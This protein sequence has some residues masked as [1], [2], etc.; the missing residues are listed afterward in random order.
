MNKFELVLTDTRILFGITL[1]RI[2]ALVAIEAFGVKPGD[3]G[4]YIEKESNLSHEG[5]AWVYGNAEVSGSARVFDN[6]QVS[7]SA[8]VFDSAEVC[9]S[10]QVY[11]S[12]W[13]CGSARVYDN[14]WVSGSALVYDDAR[15]S[16]NAWVCGNAQVYGNAWVCGQL[17]VLNL[18]GLRWSITLD[19]R[20][21]AGF[22]CQH[23]SM[24]EWTLK[25]A[26]ANGLSAPLYREYKKLIVQ[27]RKVQNM[28]LKGLGK[29]R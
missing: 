29:K 5:N 19:S 8:R 7:G 17:Q 18:I 3:L 14:A 20:E 11:G 22:G 1:Y 12:A 26:K 2:K 21:G 6:A 23:K 4:G 13:V 16:D 27:M 15:V 25:A 28:E 9:G 10:A 24:K